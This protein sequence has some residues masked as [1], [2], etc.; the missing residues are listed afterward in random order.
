MLREMHGL[1]SGYREN[2]LLHTTIRYS[3]SRATSSEMYSLTPEGAEAIKSPPLDIKNLWHVVKAMFASRHERV[4]RPLGAA[5]DSGGEE[6]EEVVLADA[7][8]IDAEEVVEEE[9]E[10]AG[11]DAEMTDIGLGNVAEE[12][13][14]EEEVEEGV[15]TAV[16]SDA[17]ERTGKDDEEELTDAHEKDVQK[18]AVDERLR[19]YG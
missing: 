9:E 11:S 17:E 3:N 12:E 13:T 1:V 18:V 19:I 15:M 6:E 5:A 16:D 4:L 14:Q 8:M 2:R 7:E 10:V